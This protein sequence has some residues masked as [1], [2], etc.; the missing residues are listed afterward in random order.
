MSFK[1][2]PSRSALA[3]PERA[4]SRNVSKLGS[5][6]QPE[7]PRIRPSN[8][9]AYC[10][11]RINDALDGL[12][13]ACRVADHRLMPALRLGMVLLVVPLAGW[14]QEFTG[15]LELRLERTIGATLVASK[16]KPW[17]DMRFP[18]SPGEELY[19]GVLEIGRTP[20]DRISVSATEKPGKEA[21]LFLDLNGNHHLDEGETFQ[22]RRLANDPAYE[23][24]VRVEIPLS[25][26]PY[27][28]FEMRF[29]IPRRGK[30]TICSGFQRAI[31]VEAEPVVVGHVLVEGRELRAA[32]Y[33][34]L[35][36]GEVKPDWR[37]GIDSNFDGHV[38]FSPTSPESDYGPSPV[39][40]V[41]DRYF[42]TDTVDLTAG[43]FQLRERAGRDYTRIELVEGTRLPAFAFD[44][45]EG[46]HHSSDE[47]R[48][49][50]LLIHF[51][52][53]PCSPCFQD[54]PFL[55]QAWDSLRP[56]GL[57][58]LGVYGQPFDS[59]AAEAALKHGAAW[60]L[61]TGD[62][63]GTWKDRLRIYAWPTIF[64][65][66][67]QGRIV[68]V[69]TWPEDVLRSERLVKTLQETLPKNTVASS[70]LGRSR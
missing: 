50:W 34:S 26:G 52:E 61:A 38:D 62:S 1:S 69:S 30:E 41:G 8:W 37:Q 14:A 47:Y 10:F 42:S 51:W 46:L 17:P 39:F 25:R 56:R 4:A 32:W 7:P 31:L 54:F 16:T 6:V 5:A 22:F 3:E 70:M 12:F 27:R 57:E 35:A 23:Q 44:D 28:T 53:T 19:D 66:D 68:V 40:R 21:R 59:K 48:G 15:E 20:D 36:E 67:P 9:A 2:T 33:Y 58:I 13:S 29:L 18:Y 24:E 60:T 11:D 49:R 45:F 55:R 65:V 43:T 64:L 63:L